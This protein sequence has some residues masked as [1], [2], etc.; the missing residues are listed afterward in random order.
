MKKVLTVIFVSLFLLSFTA[1]SFAEPAFV[2]KLVRGVANIVSAPLEIFKQTD[3]EYNSAERKPLGLVGG[4]FKGI[5]FTFA[6]LASGVFDVL[7]FPFPLQEEYSP[8]V[9]PDFVD[10]GW[11]K[12]AQ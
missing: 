5:G 10:Q 9:K 1:P 3:A 11:G 12:K 2:T 4:I 8:I 6:R 7:T